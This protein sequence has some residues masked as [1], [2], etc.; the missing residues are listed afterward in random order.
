M[1]TEFQL[2][3]TSTNLLIK[4]FKCFGVNLSEM[5]NSKCRSSVR[6]F[7]IIT[8]SF[9]QMILAIWLSICKWNYMNIRVTAFTKFGEYCICTLALGHLVFYPEHCIELFNLIDIP[10]DKSAKNWSPAQLLIRNDANKHAKTVQKLYFAAG[11]TLWLFTNF[12]PCVL[13]ICI[14]LI[15]PLEDIS[16]NDLYTSFF[17]I[18]YL[19]QN[20]VLIYSAL[21]LIQSFLYLIMITSN[22][23]YYSVITTAIKILQAEVKIFCISVQ[24]TGESKLNEVSS[25]LLIAFN[26]IIT[27]Q[28]SLELYCTLETDDP[29]MHFLRIPG[30]V[31]C[32]GVVCFS[33]Q[34]LINESENLK[35]QLEWFPWTD[36]PQWF[37]KSILIM[38]TCAKK[39]L[40]LKP[41]SLYVLNANNLMTVIQAAYS[42]LNM[43]RSFKANRA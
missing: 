17:F 39:P 7:I 10:L 28:M 37:K 30:S 3:P 2:H 24:A 5:C 34:G 18:P 9:I 6:S 38:I 26:G 19:T 25:F 32:Y 1:E 35:R 4:F 23:L 27:A 29:W 33:G 40:Q 22:A 21:L 20:T 8:A 14:L 31:V 42:Y 11:I 13:E 41:S 12:T 36:S 43:M 15:K 16:E